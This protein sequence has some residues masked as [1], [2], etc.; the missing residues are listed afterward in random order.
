MLIKKQKSESKQSNGAQSDSESSSSES[1]QKSS[2]CKSEGEPNFI[3]EQ[4]EF[5][6]DHKSVKLFD[7]L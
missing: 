3:N 4:Y 2:D 5:D 7:L 6:K 1:E